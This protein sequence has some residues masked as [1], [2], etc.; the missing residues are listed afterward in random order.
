MG[1]C[2]ANG[3]EDRITSGILA[4]Y[5]PETGDD[6]VRVLAGYARRASARVDAA[7][8]ARYAVPVS[9][10]AAQPLL[11]DLSLTLALWQ[12][13][14]DRGRAS[15]ELPAGVQQPYEHALRVLEGLAKGDLQLPGALEAAGSAAGLQVTSPEPQFAPDSPGMEFS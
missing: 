14:A 2:D 5:V 10:E 8:S 7:L 9:A 12:I 4:G 15:K 6:R 13:A 11:E 1:Y 3:L